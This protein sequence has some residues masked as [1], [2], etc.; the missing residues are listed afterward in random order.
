MRAE[1]PRLGASPLIPSAVVDLQP[2]QAVQIWMPSKH[3]GNLLLSLPAIA[4]LIERFQT[5]P[6]TLVIDAAYRDIMAAT[7]V[8]AEIIYFP[9]QTINTSG[10]VGKIREI[11]QFIAA[12]R[13]PKPSASIAI[14]GDKVSQ[15]FLPLSGC[16]TAI[17]PDNRYCKNFSVKLPLNADE[18]HVFF[19]YEAVSQQLTG[20]PTTPSYLPLSADIE[21]SETIS[22]LLQNKL[23]FPNNPYVIL[24]PCATKDYKQ[25]PTGYFAQVA[26]F[27]SAQRIN[28]IATGAGEFDSATINQ[29][30]TLS[31]SPIISL[32]N[33]LNL[34]QFIALL[35]NA[36]A[37]V[38][39]DTGPTHLAASCG[40]PTFAIFGPTDEFLWGPVGSNATI[41]RS[42]VAC[43][44][45][46][47]RRQCAENYRCML[48]LQPE[49]LI[50][51]IQKCI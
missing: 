35:Q 13:S 5:S 41:V 37:F 8:T 22:N 15:R 34:T 32:H 44:S 9:R 24:H 3:M 20:K 4:A 31:T 25:W 47:L 1:T 17:G 29:L 39:N 7:G 49:V 38:G 10:V 42:D 11:L 2:N 40:I 48:T 12:I 36:S 21:T 23:P 18:K 33:Q 28:V 50:E 19:D 6:T 43:E 51:K 14:E 16:T 45:A 27:L 30:L 46:C 26:D